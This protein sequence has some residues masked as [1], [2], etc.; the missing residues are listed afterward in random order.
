[1]EIKGVRKSFGGFEAVKGVSMTMVS[2]EVTALL[3]HNG[4]GTSFCI[5][6]SSTEFRVFQFLSFAARKNYTCEHS[7][8]RD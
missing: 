3:G 8:H 6:L 4:A 1:M 7:E 2:G 5:I